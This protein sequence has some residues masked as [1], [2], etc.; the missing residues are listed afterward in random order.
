[1]WPDIQDTVAEPADVSSAAR[2][3]RSDVLSKLTKPL[4]QILAT[5]VGADFKQKTIK[6]KVVESILC[7]EGFGEYAG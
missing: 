4:L 3:D 2:N 6:A 5:R 1:M 7:A